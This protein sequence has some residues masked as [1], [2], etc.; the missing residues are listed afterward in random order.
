VEGRL[1]HVVTTARGPVT[2]VGLEQR[3]QDVAGV[4]AAAVVGVGPAGT[5]QVVVVV[6][7]DP[8]RALRRRGAPLLAT[9]PLTAAVRAVARGLVTAPVAAVLVADALPVDIRHAAKVDRG[10]VAAWAA[11]V[12]TGERAGGRP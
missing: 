7:P 12:L 10:R 5:Q 6:V 2:P 11:R 4:A 3:V 8:G 9:A 1:V